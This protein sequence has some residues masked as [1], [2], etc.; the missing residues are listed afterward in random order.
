M[1]GEAKPFVE[2]DRPRDYRSSSGYW[3]A[4]KAFFLDRINLHIESGK[5]YC[6]ACNEEEAASHP[7]F[8]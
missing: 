2:K 5:P 6:S 8:P 1:F 4:E 7:K 3:E